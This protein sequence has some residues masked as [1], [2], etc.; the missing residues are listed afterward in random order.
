MTIRFLEIFDIIIEL[1]M[2]KSIA[3]GMHMITSLNKT[4]FQNI[5]YSLTCIKLRVLKR[6]EH[7]VSMS[8]IHVNR[9]STNVDMPPSTNGLDRTCRHVWYGYCNVIKWSQP[10]SWNKKLDVDSS[11][12]KRIWLQYQMKSKHKQTF[13]TYCTR[14]FFV[15][16]GNKY[17]SIH[18]IFMVRFR[19]EDTLSPW[20]ETHNLWIIHNSAWHLL[21]SRSVVRY[22]LEIMLC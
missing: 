11:P 12:L 5:L 20:I 4:N 10:L 2:V 18:P 8:F 9:S 16:C 13:S 6:S 21:Y 22:I 3:M 19:Y 17:R 1:I 14:V 15:E 7:F